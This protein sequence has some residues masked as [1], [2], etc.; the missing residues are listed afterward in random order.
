MM[1][2]KSTED[3]IDELDTLRAYSVSVSD[4][5]YAQARQ[6]DIRLFSLLDRREAALLVLRR[7]SSTPAPKS[8]RIRQG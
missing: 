8:A 3:L 6:V 1:R 2:V 7:A 5:A 4:A